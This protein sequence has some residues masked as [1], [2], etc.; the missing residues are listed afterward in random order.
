MTNFRRRISV[1]LFGWSISVR[2]IST[3][4][5]RGRTLVDAGE[6]QSKSLMDVNASNPSGSPPQE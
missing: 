1:G 4:T 5:F 2:E 3:E 6:L